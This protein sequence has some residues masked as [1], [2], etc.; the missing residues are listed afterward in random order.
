MHK[1]AFLRRDFAWSVRTVSS[2][3]SQCK[4]WVEY[5][6]AARLAP[7]PVSGAHLIGFI[8]WLAQEREA[9]R[10]RVGSTSLPQYISAMRQMQQVSMGVPVPNYAMV[11]VLLQAYGKWEEANFPQAAVRNG[12][13]SQVMHQ[14]WGM[15]MSTQSPSLLRDAAV[16]LFAYVMNGLRESSVMTVT[17]ENVDLSDEVISAR[18]SKVKGKAA[19]RAQLVSYK[20]WSNVPG[21]IEV[22]KRWS[23]ARHSHSRFFALQGECLVP[24]SQVMSRCLQNCLSRLESQLPPVGSAHHTHSGLG[25]IRSKC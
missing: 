6:D 3:N 24:S 4:C 1:A 21:P 12:I 15:G 5:Y 9:N 2:G 23:H 20:R 8:G 14:V 16:C 22:W 10:R 19:S 25:H 7:M 13:S 18:L 17:V 11:P